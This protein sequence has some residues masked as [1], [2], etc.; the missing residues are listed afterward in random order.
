MKVLF[1]SLRF[2]ISYLVSG[3][4][5][6]LSGYE[7]L[8]EDVMPDVAAM[9]F[10]LFALVIAIIVTLVWEMYLKIIDLTKRIE[11]IEQNKN[12]YQQIPICRT[13]KEQ[14]FR[15]LLL[16]FCSIIALW[17][18][19]SDFCIVICVIALSTSNRRRV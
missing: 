8:M 13:D 11:E 17:L 19:L 7:N 3:V 9:T 10:L 4:A 2:L 1:K 18:I 12:N 6:Y 16:L 15:P 14:R 5:E